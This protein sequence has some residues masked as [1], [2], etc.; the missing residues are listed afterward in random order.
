MSRVQAKND[1]SAVAE[2]L[3][4][5]KEL[6]LDRFNTVPFRPV[7]HPEEAEANLRRYIC[8][9]SLLT[10]NSMIEVMR[11]RPNHE[12]TSR[13]VVVLVMEDLGIKGRFPLN[14]VLDDV[15]YHK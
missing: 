15:R 12:D 7:V 11:A 9:L 8:D 13:E 2:I 1:T 10:L 3:K 5:V 14:D 6:L 4:E